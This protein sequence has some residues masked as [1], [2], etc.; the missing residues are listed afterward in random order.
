MAKNTQLMKQLSKALPLKAKDMPESVPE[1]APVSSLAA[2]K[3]SVSLYA[4][5][6]ARLDAIKAFMQSKGFRNIADS[7]A[8]RL[9]CRAV[10]IGDDMVSIFQD[11]QQED[12]R[13][14]RRAS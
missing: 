10:T 5:D 1:S 4:R 12:G 6:L 13:T 8:L 11:M 14:R 9:A 2:T 7:E 3:L